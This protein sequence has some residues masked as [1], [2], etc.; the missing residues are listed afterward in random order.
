MPAVTMPG[1]ARHSGTV[2]AR[3]MRT[4]GTR[5]RR[6]HSRT[7]RTHG[8]RTTRARARTART[9]GTRTTWTHATA[10]RSTRLLR[11]RDAT[12]RQGQRGCD[13]DSLLQWIS[14]L[15]PAVRDARQRI[16]FALFYDNRNRR[17]LDRGI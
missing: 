14:P 17:G 3:T 6:A 7:T 11:E 10:T 16:T 2:R 9:D 4:H 12:K 8:T 13:N 15:A 5:T 1:A